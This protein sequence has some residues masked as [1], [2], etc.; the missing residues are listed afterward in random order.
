MLTSSYLESDMT[1]ACAFGTDSFLCKTLD[2]D[3]FTR[4]LK[5][6]LERWIQN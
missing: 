3:Q 4:D 6:I 5:H 1:E 2:T